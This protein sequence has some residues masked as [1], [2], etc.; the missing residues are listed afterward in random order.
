MFHGKFININTN[1]RRQEISQLNNENFQFKKPEKEEQNKPKEAE[2]NK[3][4]N[5]KAE[6]GKIVEKN[7]ETKETE[8]AFWKINTIN[9]PQ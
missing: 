8:L 9:N 7:S 6:N 5:N 1:I 4:R 3:T 2:E